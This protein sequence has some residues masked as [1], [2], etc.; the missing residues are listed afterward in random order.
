[1]RINSH[2]NLGIV[3][4]MQP[5]KATLHKKHKIIMSYIDEG[6]KNQFCGS[7]EY[8]KEAREFLNKNLL[9]L[10]SDF[11]DV[12][13]SVSGVRNRCSQIKRRGHQKW[14]IIVWDH[15][16]IFK[17]GR[18]KHVKT[19]HIVI[20]F[21]FVLNR[22]LTK[23]SGRYVSCDAASPIFKCKSVDAQKEL[24]QE[25]YRPFEY[26][27]FSE[28]S[29]VYMQAYKG[30]NLYER[31]KFGSQLPYLVKEN[32]IQN[33]FKK[34]T[35]YLSQYESKVY[36][37]KLQNILFLKSEFD[38]YF[39]KIELI[40]FSD[41]LSQTASKMPY[42]IISV[43]NTPP[44]TDCEI[45]FSMQR[46]YDEK[47]AKNVFLSLVIPVFAAAIEILSDIKMPDG[48]KCCD[49]HQ[50]QKTEIKKALDIL[51]KSDLLS[52]L[53]ER[54]EEFYFFSPKTREKIC[55]K[56]N[57]LFEMAFSLI[58][59]G[60]F[61]NILPEDASHFRSIQASIDKILNG[62]NLL[63]NP[64][65]N[66]KLELLNVFYAAQ[67]GQ[68]LPFRL[69]RCE[70]KNSS[71]GDFRVIIWDGHIKDQSY[72]MMA[73]YRGSEKHVKPNHLTFL[74]DKDSAELK[75]E[76]RQF[77]TQKPARM[78]KEWPP[79]QDLD[80]F[81]WIVKTGKDGCSHEVLMA[82]YK[83]MNLE[84][85]IAK[86]A[87]QMTHEIKVDLIHKLLIAN[88][89]LLKQKGLDHV[90]DQKCG[91]VLI[92]MGRD[93]KATEINIIDYLTP[94][95]ETPGKVPLSVVMKFLGSSDYLDKYHQSDLKHCILILVECI[96]VYCSRYEK[97]VPHK[98][99]K[100]QYLS[101]QDIRNELGCKVIEACFDEVIDP[102]MYNIL[103]MG[104]YNGI[105]SLEIY[106]EAKKIII[107][108]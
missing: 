36:D 3:E 78:G 4:T 23:D 14:E 21:D 64:F 103:L 51:R 75:S 50:M 62:I 19:N 7:E 41:P 1:M 47:Y 46:E 28:T 104:Q 96:E 43:L 40:D 54:T 27:S 98:F 92:R 105:V 61:F 58:E 24:L 101:I 5:S 9:L 11:L 97:S 59:E 100:D 69:G 93:K 81:H 18:Y 30:E 70:I 8:F 88:Y 86:N 67:N 16:N 82:P 106:E 90:T 37:F 15:T 99:E 48:S 71:C 77:V 84:Y 45:D 73:Y 10:M 29:L 74:L 34:W 63:L 94:Y 79:Q 6:L 72:E 38:V 55:V 12:S 49:I 66:L 20:V 87:S 2:I 85:Y 33:I 56:K 52:F 108:G 13:D 80:G 25:G 65:S 32:L 107:E 68:N 83:G 26:V 53:L 39:Q 76:I 42:S 102:L 91:N 44:P 95:A 60:G 89:D 17:C 35:E 22:V 31:L 57:D